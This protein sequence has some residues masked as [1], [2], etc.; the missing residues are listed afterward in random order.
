MPNSCPCGCI[1]LLS[2]QQHVR[3]YFFPIALPQ[4]ALS[5]FWLFLA[6]WIIER[7]H[8][9]QCYFNLHFFNYEQNRALFTYLKAICVSFCATCLLL[10]FTI[11]QFFNAYA[12]NDQ[13]LFITLAFTKDFHKS[14]YLILTDLE[15]LRKSKDM[16]VE[17][18]QFERQ[19]Y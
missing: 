3:I 11:E 15:S 7:Q 17:M 4:S 19:S 8:L 12:K 10:S 14:S 2:H 13:I 18:E 6:N 5:N 1:P 9:T 16:T